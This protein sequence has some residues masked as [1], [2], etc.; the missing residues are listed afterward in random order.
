MTNLFFLLQTFSFL[1]YS[2]LIIDFPRKLWLRSGTSTR[3]CCLMCMLLMK[4]LPLLW[5]C[6][7][8][9]WCKY[10]FSK[11]GTNKTCE[12]PII[13]H[14]MLYN[15]HWSGM[16]VTLLVTFLCWSLN[17][18][19]INWCK[20]NIVSLQQPVMVRQFVLLIFVVTNVVLTYLA[21]HD[22]FTWVLLLHISHWSPQK[23]LGIRN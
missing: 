8:V 7:K 18:K 22:K 13:K 20:W 19:H 5:S 1:I 11:M 21:D 12:A 10:L 23:L 6:N 15:V 2:S 14:V 3:S 9:S 4:K 17:K 16:L